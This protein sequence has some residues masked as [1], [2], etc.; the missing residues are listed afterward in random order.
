MK[1][2]KVT[3]FTVIFSVLLMS[4]NALKTAAFDQYSY[5]KSIEIKIEAQKLMEKATDDFKN[6]T[7]EVEDLQTEVEK[8]VEYEKYKPNNEVTY[9]MW[10]LL[11]NKD[12]NLLSGFF[13][14]WEEEQ[15]LNS[16]FVEEAEKI[17]VEAMDLLI[18]Y[19]SQKDPEVK[20]KL[21][22]IISKN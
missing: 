9:K 19:E 13:K 5:Q 18:Q 1:L 20:T 17:I 21:L 2:M 10:Q 8:M 22:D 12:K 4:C 6:F 11:S 16:F 14:R 3:V 15:Q 7:E